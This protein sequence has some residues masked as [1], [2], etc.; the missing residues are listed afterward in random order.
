MQSFGCQSMVD[1]LKFVVLKHPLNSHAAQA[2][3]D[4][5]WRDL[6]YLGRPDFGRVVEEYDAFANLLVQFEME[7]GYLPSHEQ[8]GLDSI[9]TH[10][11]L[12][13]SNQGAILCNMGK[14]ARRG[15]ADAWAAYLPQIGVPI[16]GR[17]TPPGTLEGGD[18]LWV[19]ARTVAVGE[20]Y[21]TNAEGIRQLRALL[22][23]AVDR[24]IPVPLPH[25]TGPDDCLHLLSFISP[26][27]HKMAVVYSRLMPVPFRQWLLAQGWQLIEVPDAEYDSM[28]TNVLAVAPGQCIMLAGNPITQRRLEEAGVKV[29]TYPGGD[30]CI[31]G[32][33]GPTCLT[34]PIWRANP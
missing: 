12:V 23:N 3:I 22:G 2:T 10:D 1:E 4:A 21:R 5:Q 11:P 15:E 6:F 25:W 26:V 34:R 17:I 32:G 13:I 9:Y 31:K 19:D 14:P 7:I 16:L 8:T 27:D 33:G 20:G 24:V 30:L 28:A 29:W 18:V